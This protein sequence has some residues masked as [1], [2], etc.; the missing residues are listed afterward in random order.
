MV[1]RLRGDDTV[2]VSGQ[3]YTLK[4][5]EDSSG[6]SLLEVL[7]SLIVFSFSM[8]ALLHALC[9]ISNHLA[10]NLEFEI[11]NH[12]LISLSERFKANGNRNIAR[13]LFA[14]NKENAALLRHGQ[15][16]IKPLSY[17][18]CYAEITW[19]NHNNEKQKL[20]LTLFSSRSE[21]A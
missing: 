5:C 14:W 18:K 9:L 6:F 12:Q 3:K 16:H 2:V 19:I 1:P 20:T 4:K 13:E 10:S 7:I 11:A 15:G 21:L 8:L 17:R